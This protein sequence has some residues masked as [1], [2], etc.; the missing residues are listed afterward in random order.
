[1]KFSIV[2]L[3][4]PYSRQSVLSAYRFAEAVLDKGHTL[5]RVFFY[6]DGVHCG[7]GLSQP[8]QDEASVPEQWA[9]LGNRHDLDLVV[10]ISSALKRG[11][12]DA[13]EADRYEKPA[14]NLHDAFNV[15]GLG[16]WVDT[17]LASDRV[18]TF[19]A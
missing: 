13:T 18:V 2:V 10:C 11:V 14:H 17:C 5:Y 1:M 8:P 12:L 4:S 9:A 6:H 7:T 15:S 16:Q 19:G 3:G